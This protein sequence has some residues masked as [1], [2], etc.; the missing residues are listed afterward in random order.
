MAT[1]NISEVMATTIENRSGK[2]RDNVLKNNALYA[3]LNKRGNVR[4]VSGGSAIMEELSYAE[5][6]NFGWYSGYDPLPINAADV[7]TAATFPWK[8]CAAAVVVSGLELLQNNGKEKIIDLVEQRQTVAESTMVNR[9]SEGIYSDGT[10]YGGKQITGLLAAVPTNPTT[11]V[12]GG[13]DR[14]TWTFWRNQALAAGHAAA[15]A[16]IQA[17][18]NTLWASLVR[19]SDRPDLIVTDQI[20]W[21]A[22]TASLQTLQRFTDSDKADLGFPSI[23]YMGAD[24]VLD[25][26]IGGFAPTKTMWFLNTKY[27]YL[28][29]HT[30]RNMVPIDPR[31]RAPINQDAEV[32]LIGWAGALTCSGAQM[33]GVL[34][35]S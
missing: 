22:F 30:D 21:A 10:G 11:G 12:Y 7:L 9:M 13:I 3:R 28:R 6:P 14:A 19:G 15:P 27:I 20:P 25:G 4:P 31:R 17:D 5:N 35:F 24:V 34:T 8:Q 33:Q 2:I 1:P 18:M 23:S 16:T 26:G 32:M 29:P